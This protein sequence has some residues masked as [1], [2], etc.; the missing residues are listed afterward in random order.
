MS[1]KAGNEL[2][3][4]P[5]PNVV[6]TLRV[7]YTLGGEPKK[8]EIPENGVF[9]VAGTPLPTNP[10]ETSVVAVLGKR[11]DRAALPVILKLAQEGPPDVRL[12]AIQALANMGDVSAVPLLLETAASGQ[13]QAVAAL[14]SLADLPDKAVDAKLEALL[15]SSTGQQ[16]LV[17]I[18][19]LGRREIAAA[20][21]ALLKLTAG[22]DKGARDAAFACVGLTIDQSNLAAP[23]N[24]WCSRR[25]PT[26]PRRPRPRCRRLVCACPIATQPHVC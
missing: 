14:D 3:G 7:S 23:S 15:D 21:P 10:R 5:A 13:A 19:L 6:K 12:A 20:V 22:D 8:V 11:G 4:D 25:P 2:F 24:I 16:K 17:V 18:E 9:E 26:W 1:V